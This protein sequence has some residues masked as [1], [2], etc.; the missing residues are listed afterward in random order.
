MPVQ[1]FINFID[2]Y[3]NQMNIKGNH[4]LNRYQFIFITSVQ[5]IEEIYKNVSGEPRQQWMRRVEQIEV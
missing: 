5:D 3:A 2:Y 4:V 1:E